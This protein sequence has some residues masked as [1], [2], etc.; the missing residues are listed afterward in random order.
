MTRS[1]RVAF[2]KGVATVIA[3]ADQAARV[4]E[5][6]LIEKPTRYNFAHGALT[7]IVE[8]A[9]ALMMP[10]DPGLREVGVSANPKPPFPKS[11]AEDARVDA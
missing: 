4:I 3:L 8:E 1:E 11:L 2:N 5:P 10:V 6:K 7:A 9:P